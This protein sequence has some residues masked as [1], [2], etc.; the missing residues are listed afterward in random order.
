MPTP[1]G[2]R[3]SQALAAQFASAG[4]LIFACGRYEGIDARVLDY[5]A[6]RMAVREVSLGDYV[7]FGGEAAVLVIVEAVVRLLDGVL[8]NEQSAL[9]ESFSDGLLEAPTYTKPPVWR[10][11]EVP[12]VLRSGDHGAIARWRRE[13]ALLNTADRRPDLLPAP[14]AERHH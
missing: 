9:H 13:Q 8:G 7:L 4:R 11:R 6:E 10:G 14:E 12:P 3:F 5:A 2:E 1:T